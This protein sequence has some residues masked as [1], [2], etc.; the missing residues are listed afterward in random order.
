MGVGAAGYL[1][2]PYKYGR[3]TK[4]PTPLK[5]N[6]DIIGKADELRTKYRGQTILQPAS[7]PNICMRKTA[8]QC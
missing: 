1:N 5:T 8:Q 3:S 7:I 6:P 2:E 4:E